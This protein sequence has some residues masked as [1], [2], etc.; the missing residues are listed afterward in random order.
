MSRQLENYLLYEHTLRSIQSKE[1]KTH[2][3]SLHMA[4]LVQRG[5]IICT[6]TN[7]IGSRSSGAGYSDVTIHAERAVVKKLGDISKLRGCTMYVWRIGFAEY[8]PMNSEPCSECRVFLA[9]CMKQY[10][11]RG[12]YY[13]YQN[14][15]DDIL[16]DKNTKRQN[17]TTKP[18]HC[19]TCQCSSTG[20]A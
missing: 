16:M 14:T 20:K 5:K 3:F 15:P 8:Y 10:G 9:K 1:N 7:R 12:V 2:R 11:L 19:S 13:T 18:P 6:A 4:V 17:S